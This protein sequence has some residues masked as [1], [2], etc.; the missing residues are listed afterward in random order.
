MAKTLKIMGLGFHETNCVI[1]VS[2][3]DQVIY[4][5][6][7][8]TETTEPFNVRGVPPKYTLNSVVDQ[9]AIESLIGGAFRNVNDNGQQ[10][11]CSWQEAVAFQGT[12]TLK[13]E[14]VQ[15]D[16]LLQNIISNFMPVV[17]SSDAPADLYQG[18][19]SSGELG[20]VSPNDGKVTAA[21]NC[22][23][24][25]TIDALPQTR[26]SDQGFWYYPIPE[27]SVFIAVLNI[28]AGIE[29][30]TPFDPP[31]IEVS[32]G[33]WSAD[34]TSKVFNLPNLVFNKTSHK[35]FINGIETNEWMP[36]FKI[37]TQEFYIELDNAPQAGTQVELKFYQTWNRT[38]YKF[39]S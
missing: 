4:N 16:F 35:V 13:I 14:A 24:N 25:V 28:L 39:L 20:F 6:P 32:K 29:S 22:L 31:G 19:F 30:P 5:G 9:V 8:P 7:V 38:F 10:E 1:K 2:V 36:K 33:V 26:N 3:D 23:T 12:R 18:T 21:S 11:C 34:G 27:N 15:G 17:F 37:D